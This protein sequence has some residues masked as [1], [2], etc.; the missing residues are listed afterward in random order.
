LAE[1]VYFSVKP[2]ES[3]TVREVMDSTSGEDVIRDV[4]G[5]EK[6]ENEEKRAYVSLKSPSSSSSG[7]PFPSG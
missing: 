4:E 5:E 6:H 2:P 7:K 1:V 3:S